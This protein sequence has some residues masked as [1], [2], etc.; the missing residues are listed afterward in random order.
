[1]EEKGDL[2]GKGSGGGR[3]GNVGV[4]EEEG[5]GGVGEVV[6]EGLGRRM[7]RG[8]WGYSSSPSIV[9]SVWWVGE[10]RWWRPVG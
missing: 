6:G 1:L 3:E 4:G 7:V 9:R 10:R 2:K 5:W 8:K